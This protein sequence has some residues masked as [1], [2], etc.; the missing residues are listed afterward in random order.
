MSPR[1][2]LHDRRQCC[3]EREVLVHGPGHVVSDLRWTQERQLVLKCPGVRRLFPARFED[4][5]D[6]VLDLPF[7]LV[8]ALDVSGVDVGRPLAWCSGL[9]VVT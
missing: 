6:A 2:E 7:D 3:G 8:V 1:T 4:V 9:V 5:P